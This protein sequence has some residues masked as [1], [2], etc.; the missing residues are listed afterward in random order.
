MD[1]PIT[2]RSRSPGANLV[3]V[4]AIIARGAGIALLFPGV[5][6][7]L[8]TTTLHGML[9]YG[10]LATIYLGIVVRLGESVGTLLWH[11]VALQLPL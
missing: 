5:A 11:A 2:R 7:W 1:C 10:M 6:C 3:G 9:T 4:S 8:R